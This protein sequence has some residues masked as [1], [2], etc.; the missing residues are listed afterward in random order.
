MS[1]K[2]IQTWIRFIGNL[3]LFSGANAATGANSNAVHTNY[4]YNYGV[5]ASDMRTRTLKG[6]W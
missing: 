1:K 6:Y 4:W 5:V 2:N 3:T